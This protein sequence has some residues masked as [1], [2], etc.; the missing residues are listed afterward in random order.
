[1]LAAVEEAGAAAL[2][3]GVGAGDDQAEGEGDGAQPDEV[4]QRPPAGARV[5]QRGELP[6]VQQQYGQQRQ[7][8]A[9]A[10]EGVPVDQLGGGADR[11]QGDGGPP[12]PLLAALERVRQHQQQDAGDHGGGGGQ[13]ADG[14]GEDRGHVVHPAVA[15]G[16]EDRGDHVEQAD[17]RRR[18]A[19]DLGYGGGPHR[20]AVPARGRLLVSGHRPPPAEPG[21]GFRPLPGQTCATKPQ[22]HRESRVYPAICSST[23]NLRPLGRE[24]CRPGSFP[25]G[26]TGRRRRKYTCRHGSHE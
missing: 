3:R 11:Q 18:G 16:G 19:D 12:G 14:A 22:H 9:D 23:K 20:P 1:M 24:L 25:A 26:A 17:H 2:G 21:P 15:E 5:G 4:Q 13:R 10:E 7:R 6:P 8:H